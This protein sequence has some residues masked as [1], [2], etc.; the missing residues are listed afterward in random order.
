MILVS[1]SFAY[2]CSK[3]RKTKKAGR[4]DCKSFF[5]DQLARELPRLT[6]AHN[7]RTSA[8]IGWLLGLGFI[9]RYKSVTDCSSVNA[10]IR[11]DI[12]EMI[13]CLTK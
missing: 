3:E 8:A 1:V 2:D 6:K 5:D 11:D 4:R 10:G 13:F 7:S 9:E 12:P